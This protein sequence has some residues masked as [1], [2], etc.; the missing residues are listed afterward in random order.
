MCPSRWLRR[1]LLLLFKSKI[2]RKYEQ[3]YFKLCFNKQINYTNE[4]I[5]C[6][7]GQCDT[8]TKLCIPLLPPNCSL[9][10]QFMA[11]KSSTFLNFHEKESNAVVTQGKKRPTM[12][13]TAAPKRK[14]KKPT[15]T[16]TKSTRHSRKPTYKPSKPI[17]PKVLPH[18]NSQFLK[19]NHIFKN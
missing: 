6:C 9:P 10:T 12:T 16:P 5:P 4:G 17:A 11:S 1:N 15:A 2:M 3:L 19:I 13:P 18:Y 7:S 8:K 14:S